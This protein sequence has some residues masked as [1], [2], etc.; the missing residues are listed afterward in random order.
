[1][2]QE[3]NALVALSGAEIEAVNGGW[4]GTGWPGQWGGIVVPPVPEPDP[5]YQLGS[6]F[7]LVAL[8]PQ[9]L[10]PKAIFSF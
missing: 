5:W 7:D 8:N 6:R 4:C 9:P 3:E 10:P 1:M 2:H